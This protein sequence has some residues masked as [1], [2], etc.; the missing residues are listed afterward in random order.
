[1][2]I[3]T[4]DITLRA[5]NTETHA[6]ARAVGGRGG[7]PLSRIVSKA[8]IVDRELLAIALTEAV[9]RLADDFETAWRQQ[10]AKSP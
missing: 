8:G 5:G 6:I 1:M 10:E 3:V 9:D 2:M 7:A 4:V